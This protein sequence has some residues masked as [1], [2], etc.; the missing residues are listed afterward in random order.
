MRA[1]FGREIIAGDKAKATS[2]FA[3]TMGEIL[4]AN[5]CVWIQCGTEFKAIDIT[6]NKICIQ[7]HMIL[8]MRLFF[9]S[10]TF[11]NEFDDSFH[12]HTHTYKPEIRM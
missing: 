10:R 1:L 8:R 5:E 4:I 6:P 2:T 9:G 3:N 11:F 7:R 12:T